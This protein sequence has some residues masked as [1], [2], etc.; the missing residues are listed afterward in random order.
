M[1][2]DKATAE[3]RAR[4][5]EQLRSL[6]GPQPMK[7]IPPELMAEFMANPEPVEEVERKYRELVNGG[8]LSI[9]PYLDELAKK[10]LGNG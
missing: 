6:P 9:E 7:P 1:K 8:G 2:E 5:V 10:Y 3:A 4:I